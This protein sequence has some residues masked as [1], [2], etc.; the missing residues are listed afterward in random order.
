[1][2]KTLASRK[3]GK[4]LSLLLFAIGLVVTTFYGVW[5]PAIMLVVGMPL[6][7]YQY[8]QG[9]PYDAA[10]SV[11]VF[12]GVFCTV[13][14][15]IAWEI[16][17]PVLFVVGGIYIFFREFIEVPNEAELEEDLN[18]EIEEEKEEKK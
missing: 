11:F 7:L 12:G 16:L 2:A 3:K 17:I 10:V 14:F 13:Q 6:A 8:L 1:M 15:D 9:R 18:E 4:L 5:W